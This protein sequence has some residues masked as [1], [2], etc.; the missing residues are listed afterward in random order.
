MKKTNVLVKLFTNNERLY[1]Y[2]ANKNRILR[3]TRNLYDE[4]NHYLQS[5]VYTSNA[6]VA[7]RRR[8]YL[9]E[10]NILNLSHPFTPFVKNLLS[11]HVS[12]IILQ[13]TQNCNFRCRYCTY[14]FNGGSTRTHTHKS[15]TL[16]VAKKSVDF[17][18]T[19]CADARDVNIAFYG[20]EPL[21]NFELIKEIVKY[22]KDVI[23]NKNIT[24]SMTTNFSVVTDEIVDFLSENRFKLL[25]SLDGPEAIQNFHRRFSTNGLGTYQT[26]VDNVIKIKTKYN[27]YFCSSVRFNPV[28]YYDENPLEV[29]N[30]F[31]KVLGVPKH[32][33]QLQHVDITGLNIAF[34]PLDL[35][36]YNEYEAL[37]KSNDLTYFESVLSDN[38]SITSMYHLNGSCVPGSG[39]LFVTVDGR[40]FP[41]EKVNE[42]NK[43]M[44]IGTLQ[45]GFDLEK[46][47]FL[48]NIGYLNQDNCKKCWAIRFCKICCAHCDDGESN[49]SEVMLKSK[50]KNTQNT[51]LKFLKKRVESDL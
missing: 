23:Y 51:V 47:K 45:E 48:M 37:F 25:I 3:I 41:C 44:Q 32:N 20:G 43:N 28:V 29:L 7:L 26:V 8:G 33:I 24:Y 19:H 30:F 31:D 40:F 38:S 16:D 1:M 50:C 27:E 5:P 17:L 4:I 15:M 9:L 22:S 21:L 36:K 10:S 18:S 39:K 49:L 46:V 35:D 42:C 13:V 2:D 11:T 6:V 34:D 14:A 12:T